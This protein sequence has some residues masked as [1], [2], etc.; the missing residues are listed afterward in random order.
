MGC[1]GCGL[2]RPYEKEVGVTVAVVNQSNL[3]KMAQ[4]TTFDDILGIHDLDVQGAQIRGLRDRLGL[5]SVEIHTKRKVSFQH[6]PNI[7]VSKIGFSSTGRRTQ[8]FFSLIRKDLKLGCFN[9]LN[10]SAFSGTDFFLGQAPYFSKPSLGKASWL[11]LFGPWK[12]PLVQ[13]GYFW[14]IGIVI[15]NKYRDKIWAVR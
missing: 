7:P 3:R 2:L 9:K 12:G 13:N 1:V 15:F 11:P 4:I 14:M 8:L 10:A 5:E 6:D